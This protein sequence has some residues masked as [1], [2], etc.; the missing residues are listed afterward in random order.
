M[1]SK[2]FNLANPTFGKYKQ[3]MNG[4]DYISSKKLKCKPCFKENT[5]NLIVNLYTKEDLQ[6][7]TTI[8]NTNLSGTTQC[9]P[10]YINNFIDPIGE[11]FG[12]SFCGVNNYTAYMRP[13]LTPHCA[14]PLATP[15][16]I[17]S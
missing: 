17:L 14:P 16:T 12:N 8:V 3:N 9:T 15:P 4:S 13:N 11:L 10:Y 5:T 1:Y 2:S 7:V 6:N